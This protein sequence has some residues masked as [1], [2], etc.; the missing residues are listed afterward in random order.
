MRTIKKLFFF[1]WLFL[2]PFFSF[3]WGVLGHRV[4]GQIAD[5]YLTPKAHIEIQK[6]LGTESMAMVS[7]WA[8]FVKSD[9]AYSYLSSWHYIDVDSGLTKNQLKNYLQNDT[10]ADLYTKTNFLVS[11]LK[12]KHLAMDKKRMYL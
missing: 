2:L 9:S 12:N 1:V 6:I 5:S 11:E 10:A 3:G 7:N 4:V 8:D